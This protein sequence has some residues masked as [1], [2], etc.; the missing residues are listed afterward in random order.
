MRHGRALVVP[1]LVCIDLQA[2]ANTQALDRSDILSVGGFT[3]AVFEV[4]AAFFTADPTRFV[5]EIEAVE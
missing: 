2:Y 1:R 3:D 4:V 5:A